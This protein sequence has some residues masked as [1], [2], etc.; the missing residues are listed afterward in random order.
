MLPPLITPLG[1]S[2]TCRGVFVCTLGWR[3]VVLARLE[4]LAGT[5]TGTVKYLNRNENEPSIDSLP[6]TSCLVRVRSTRSCA[7]RDILIFGSCF[8]LCHAMRFKGG[9]NLSLLPANTANSPGCGVF[10]QVA[11]RA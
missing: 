8:C 7:S 1:E 9:F 4:A 10:G 5:F 2:R 6:K 11:E 3:G